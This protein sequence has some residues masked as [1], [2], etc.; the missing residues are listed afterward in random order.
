[1][2][3]QAYCA[4]QVA[5]NQSHDNLENIQR[6]PLQRPQEIF[7][8]A[9]PLISFLGQREVSEAIA[10]KTIKWRMFDLC[11]YCTSFSL[12]SLHLPLPHL[13][14]LTTIEDGKPNKH[15]AAISVD[16][17]LCKTQ[18]FGA[19]LGV[20][21]DLRWRNLVNSWN[22][23]TRVEEARGSWRCYLAIGYC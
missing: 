14:L 18:E 4:K 5:T 10:R 3:V 11:Q 2:C 13:R 7:P 17:V 12:T 23:K 22:H 19:L 8:A 15:L 1:M 9:Q 16:H 21:K 6:T 20:H